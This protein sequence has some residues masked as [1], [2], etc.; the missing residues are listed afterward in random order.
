MQRMSRAD[1]NY[2]DG[3]RLYHANHDGKLSIAASLSRSK[4]RWQRI[5]S[6]LWL[7]LPI[8]LLCG[9]LAGYAS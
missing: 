1:G 2:T 6:L 8:G 5:G 9:L 3:K 4:N 7:W